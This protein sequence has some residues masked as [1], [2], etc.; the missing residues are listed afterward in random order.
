LS[1][2]QSDHA[3]I[4]GPKLNGRQELAALI[5]THRHDQRLTSSDASSLRG[6]AQWLDS[7]LIGRPCRGAFSA[8]IARQYYDTTDAITPVMSSSLEHICV[9]S[10][11]LPCRHL[12][13]EQST[14][15]PVIIYTDCATYGPTNLRV[16]VLLIHP[17][18]TFV[19]SVDVP[20]WFIDTFLLREKYIN[21][22]ELIAGPI[23]VSF[24]PKLLAN[25][26]V[27][28]FIDNTAALGA[29]IKRAS[30]VE[31]VNSLA[32]VFGLSL[33]ALNCRAW[34]EYVQSESNPSDVLSRTA[35]EDLE[36]QQRLASGEW[37]RVE[38]E[39]PW[40][41]FYQVPMAEVLE[42]FAVTG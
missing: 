11:H 7:K 2:I 10:K 35:W 25:Q 12:P 33:T 36:V 37:V 9:V 24:F 1:R 30:S 39:V 16:G 13:F 5:D 19:T 40:R 18:G 20:Q 22:G 42:F 28:W 26:D 6:K 21:L 14:T 41:K 34:F 27:I 17:T 29:L 3:V 38:A 31:D 15:K 23:A 32:L 8:L 4:F